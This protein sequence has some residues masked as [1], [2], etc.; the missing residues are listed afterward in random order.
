MTRLK[1]DYDDITF[2]DVEL[3]FMHRGWLLNRLGL[4]AVR[5]AKSRRG[6]H[7]EADVTNALDPREVILVQLLLGSDIHREIYNL[8]HHLDG[9]LIETW[10]KLFD[11]KYI[12]L[13]TR[14]VTWGVERPAP[15]LTRKLKT[16]LEDGG[17]GT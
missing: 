7:V 8:L 12:I 17:G 3:I 14:L 11:K 10:N 2:R 16:I 4:E 5:V 1:L 9:D 13:G 15:S 6:Y